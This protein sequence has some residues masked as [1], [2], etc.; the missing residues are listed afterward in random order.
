MI[1]TVVLFHSVLGR[2]PS[3]LEWAEDLRAAGHHVHTPDL[4]D[5][6]AYDDIDDGMRKLDALGPRLRER[7]FGAVAGLPAGFVVA[8]FSMGAA[9]AVDVATSVPGVRA[10]VLMNSVPVPDEPWPDGVPAQVHFAE[11]DPWVGPTDLDRFRAAADRAGAPLDVH[12][13]PGDRHMFGDAGYP[14]HDPD[15]AGLMRA[16]VL[17]FLDRTG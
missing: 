6:E 15:L 13:Y 2:R 8:G 5:G 12:V 10:A 7:I 4:F 3:I 11:G 14:D 9:V 17:D 1:H 16:R